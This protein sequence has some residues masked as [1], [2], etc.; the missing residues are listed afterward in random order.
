MKTKKHLP[1]LLIILLFLV[2]CGG[3]G[4]DSH[5]SASCDPMKRGDGLTPEITFT[6]VPTFN[7][8]ENLIG[9]VWNVS[10]K[11]YGL[12]IL[13]NVGGLW[14]SKPTDVAPVTLIA[15]NCS[16]EGDVTTGGSDH[17][18]TRIIAYLIPITYK[19]PVALGA[20][21]IPPDIIKNAITF[22]E[23]VR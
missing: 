6:Q 4:D 21:D 16:F 10:P 5:P 17:L 20:K 1:I 22:K 18:A 12:A 8:T 14:W 7:T 9:M 19:P 13:I 23:A 11:N 15:C 2:G 3:G